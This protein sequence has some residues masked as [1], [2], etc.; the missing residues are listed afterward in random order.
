[1]LIYICNH[2][3]ESNNP[4]ETRIICNL[5]ARRGDVPIAPR[6]YFPQFIHSN[7]EPLSGELLSLCDEVWVIGAMTDTM[8]TEVEQA[9]RECIPVKCYAN[10]EAMARALEEKTIPSPSAANAGNGGT[11]RSFDELMGE[12]LKVNNEEEEKEIIEFAFAK[13]RAL[14][15]RT[16]MDRGIVEKI[17]FVYNSMLH[18]MEKVEMNEEEK[19]ILLREGLS[20][21]A[22]ELG[23]DRR[24]AAAV[25]LMSREEQEDTDSIVEVITE[26]CAECV[27]GIAKVTGLPQPL[28]D[29]VVFISNIWR[30]RDRKE[31]TM[32]N[33]DTWWPK[34]IKDLANLLGQ[35]ESVIKRVLDAELSRQ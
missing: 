2:K 32:G 14:E 13:A 18:D 4:A 22:D 30:W 3:E 6:L 23:I 10:T 8:K 29:K 16:H 24:L 20:Q 27:P 17:L 31:I 19:G 15:P 26:Y 12:L 34:H 33:F 5:I 1:M 7:I 21:I 28:V 11:P 25:L 9:I 35:S